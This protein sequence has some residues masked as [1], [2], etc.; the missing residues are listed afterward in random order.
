MDV[1]ITTSIILSKE[2]EARTYSYWHIQDVSFRIRRVH[3]RVKPHQRHNLLLKLKYP[4]IRV[5]NILFLDTRMRTFHR[6]NL[7]S[8]SQMGLFRF[9][10]SVKLKSLRSKGG[11]I[12]YLLRYLM[13][14]GCM[15][16][17][18]L[19]WLIGRL[20]IYLL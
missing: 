1:V 10:R 17:I 5:N 7:I 15:M 20:L 8:Y 19:I 6:S 4:Q 2:I 16:I 18:I 12:R 14:L 9:L 3:G 11:L 13:L